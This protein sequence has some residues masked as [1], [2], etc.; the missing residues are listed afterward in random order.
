[1]N[2]ASENSL[3]DSSVMSTSLP[4]INLNSA[5][6]TTENGDTLLS[7]SQLTANKTVLANICKLK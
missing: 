3:S 1:M 5:A 2:T 4:A 7:L 6:T